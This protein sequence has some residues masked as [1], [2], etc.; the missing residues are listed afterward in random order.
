M[1]NPMGLTIPTAGVT[2]GPTYAENVSNDLVIISNHTHTGISNNDGYQVPSAGLNI[3]ADLSFQENNA[4]DLRSTRYTDQ[5]DVL[6]GV[7]DVNCLYFNQGDVWINNGNG[8]PV[9]I[10]AGTTLV[11]ETSTS[12]SSTSKGSNF[13]IDAFDNFNVYQVSTTANP[14]L[15]TLPSAGDVAVGRFYIFK[16]WDGTANIN[17]ITI[18]G[19]GNNLDGNANYVIN[20]PY[21]A[22]M[23]IQIGGSKWTVFRYQSNTNEIFANSGDTIT[24]LSANGQT[25]VFCSTLSSGITINLPLASLVNS[26]CKITIKDISGKAETNNITIVPQ[27]GDTIEN[28]S[29]DK[30]IQVGYGSVTLVPTPSYA[31]NTWV[32]V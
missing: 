4:T 15:A 28:L 1:S 21:G 31:N 30:L 2:A 11:T 6:V 17:N 3:N 14:V 27:A 12:Y 26:E 7:G 25:S 18:Q 32:M 24:L 23:V 5:D 9:Q 10:T 29:D 19:A 8:T 13:T 16:D 20:T 22:V